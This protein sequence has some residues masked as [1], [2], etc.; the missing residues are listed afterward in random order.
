MS[1]NIDKTLH[2]YTR[3]STQ[4][5]QDSGTSLDTQKEMGIKR[6]EELGF[7]YVVW[8]EGGMSSHHEDIEKRP[9]LSALYNLIKDN[10]VRHI[11][12]Y[13]QSRLSRN[14]FVASAFRYICNKHSVTLYTKDVTHDLANPS[15]MLLK[16]LLDAISQFDNA[17]RTERFRLGK[18]KRVQDGFWHGGPPVYGY[19][20]KD[21]KLIINPDEAKWVVEI[22]KMYSEGK[23][24][25][26]IKNHLDSNGVMTRRNKGLWTLGSLQII[27]KHTHYVGRYTF[28]D[29]KEDGSIIVECPQIV[30]ISTWNNCQKRRERFLE[31]KGQIN[32]SVHF[33][34]LRD[35]LYCHHCKTP[36]GGRINSSVHQ[37]FYY[38][39]SRQ[40]K[41]V[42]NGGSEKHYDRSV[43]CG[44]K[45]SVNIDATDGIVWETV[46]NI[47][48]NSSILKEELKN[49]ALY[50][51][52]QSK[53]EIAKELASYKKAE[54]RLQKDYKIAI[55]AL[56]E[57]EANHY[58]K[59][60][61]DMIY[62]ST[63]GKIQKRIDQI[64]SDIEELKRDKNQS[65]KDS[66]WINWLDMFGSEVCSL[67]TLDD[68]SKRD[69]LEGMID[70][71]EV[72]YDEKS[73]G[74][75][76][77]IKFRR[78]IV[79]DSIQFIDVSNKKKGYRV[80]DGS[81]VKSVAYKKKLIPSQR[82]RTQK[83]SVRDNSVTVE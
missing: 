21:R 32:R 24:T 28:K 29:E 17:S 55:D 1:D 66:K 49:K 81:S 69:Y 70:R 68:K 37:N 83:T 73:N 54:K 77:I 40:N 36:L 19:A 43:S 8:N 14:D 35:L 57:L 75:E 80:I 38:C 52:V 18:L 20:L 65:N 6:A 9:K 72:R 60:V 44:L 34:L 67:D 59:Q 53:E 62:L 50:N 12:V 25:V 56:S 27:L 71:I 10:K 2:I 4:N 42:K 79:D 76:L 31:R 26:D 58:L 64:N 82:T 33:Y 13:D 61:S 41:W 16:Q 7:D 11:W 15:D 46:I 47:H 45:K 74:H 3:V 63:K 30:D 48:R 23:S 39:P 22:Y 78:P 5:Q 51:R